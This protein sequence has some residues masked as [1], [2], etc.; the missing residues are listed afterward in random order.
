MADAHALHLPSVSGGEDGFAGNPYLAFLLVQTPGLK[1]GSSE[2][3]VPRRSGGGRSPKQLWLQV[4]RGEGSRVH[5]AIDAGAA[6]EQ[7][8]GS[9]TKGVGAEAEDVQGHVHEERVY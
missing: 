3:P 1:Q 5:A 4:A 8:G 7:P 2:V 6:R 9:F